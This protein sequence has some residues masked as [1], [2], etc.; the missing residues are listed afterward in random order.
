MIIGWWE[1]G[2]GGIFLYQENMIMLI[3]Y[4]CS[5]FLWRVARLITK[6]LQ[7]GIWEQ[8]NQRMVKHGEWENEFIEDEPNFKACGNT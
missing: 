7:G 1:I 3:L 2:R 5:K 4:L 6:Y 8:G